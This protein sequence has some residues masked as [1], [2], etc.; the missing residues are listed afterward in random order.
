MLDA[1]SLKDTKIGLET[2]AQMGYAP[3]DITLVLN[4]ADTSVGISMSDVFELLRKAPEVLIPS[5]RAIPRTLTQG[6]TIYEA[7]AKSG[8][9]R[10]FAELARRYLDLTRGSEPAPMDAAINESD[11]EAEGSRRRRLLRR[12]N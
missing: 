8:A 4:R 11:G 7:E 9:A 12:G 5:D 1:L 2:L 3:D 10:G 6:Q